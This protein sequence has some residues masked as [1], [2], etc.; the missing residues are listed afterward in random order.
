MQQDRPAG[1]GDDL[2]DRPELR[3]VE[4]H[5]VDVGGDL[6]GVGAVLE[7]ALG[8][9][10]RRLRRVHRQQRRPAGELLGMFR[11]DL[12]EAVIADLRHLGRLVR[13]PHPLHRRQAVRQH[14]LVILEHVDDA[15]P[16]IDIRQG[17]NAAHPLADILGGGGRFQQRL[18]IALRKEMREGIDAA[19]VFFSL[20]TIRLC[21]KSSVRSR[22]PCNASSLRGA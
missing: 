18:V 2:V 19:H 21:G 5:A 22:M 8:L 9:L 17:R 16:Q 14:L 7:H 12:G 13:A 10:G 3:L 11:R 15:Q 4:R 1:L 6:D 20:G